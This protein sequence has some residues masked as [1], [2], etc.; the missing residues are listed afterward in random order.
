MVESVEKNR[1]VSL[2][3]VVVKRFGLNQ[4]RMVKT[5]T[6]KFPHLHMCMVAS[7]VLPPHMN[8]QTHSCKHTHTHE[9]MKVMVHIAGH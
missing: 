8:M 7:I 9:G 2:R 3:F 4:S 6:K 1:P 5:N